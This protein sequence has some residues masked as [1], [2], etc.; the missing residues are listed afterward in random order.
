MDGHTMRLGACVTLLFGALAALTTALAGADLAPVA[1]PSPEAGESPPYGRTPPELKP[2]GRWTEPHRRFFQAKQFYLPR[3]FDP[4]ETYPI[5]IP[6]GLMGYDQRHPFYYLA[7]QAERAMTLAIE[8]ENEKGGYKGKPFRLVVERTLPV[9]GASSNGAVAM[10][11]QHRVLFYVGPPDA[12]DAHIALRVNLKTKIP[13]LCTFN[14]DQTQTETRIPWYLRVNS[15][16]RQFGNALVMHMVKSLGYKR[17]G[18]FR[19]NGMYGRFGVV[20]FTDGCRR[21][22]RPLVVELRHKQGAKEFA[23]EIETLKRA[24]LDALVVWSDA[25][26]AGNAVRALRARGFAAPIFASDRVVYRAFLETAGK[27][28]EGVI[29]VTDH[30]PTRDDPALK[31]FQGAYQKRFGELPETCAARTYAGMQVAFDA[32]RKAGPARRPFMEELMKLEGQKVKTVLG[33]LDFDSRLDNPRRCWRPPWLCSRGHRRGA[34]RL[35]TGPGPWRCFSGPA[36]PTARRSS[37]GSRPVWTRPT[38]GWC[39]PSCRLRARPAPGR[40]RPTFSCGF[41]TRTGS[42]CSWSVP[43]AISATWPSSSRSRGAPGR[44]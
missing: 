10:A 17:I 6:I 26:D 5:D 11:Y 33:T 39:A 16:D 29:A 37:P 24:H 18:I 19:V 25:V 35:R 15:D 7:E 4:E 8:E 43:T 36:R 32:I 23:A 21:L 28:A 30:D 31:L 3:S 42:G 41:F 38:S 12:S 1:S 40:G 44:S 9:W 14:T 13:M 2:F 34:T 27:A 20:E 22:G